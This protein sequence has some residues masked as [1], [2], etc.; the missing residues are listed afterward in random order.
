MG[1]APMMA[2]GKEVVSMVNSLSSYLKRIS[3]SMM[4]MCR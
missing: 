1:P 2:T 4:R 3:A